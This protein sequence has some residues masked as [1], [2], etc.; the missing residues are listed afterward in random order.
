M[1]EK[2]KLSWITFIV[3]GQ[4]IMLLIASGI[5]GITGFLSRQNDTSD[6]PSVYYEA[7]KLDGASTAKVFVN[8]TL[9]MISPVIFYVLIMQMVSAL[10]IFTQPFIMT[11]GGPM[12]STYTFGLHLYNQAFRY[13]DFGY[14]CAL[15]WVLFAMIMGI[16]MVIF[17]TSR[18]WV[19][20]REDVDL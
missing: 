16:S 17:K 14:S 4:C 13:Y 6:V 1:K 15:A 18:L 2:I 7:A 3:I 5:I 8:I 10:Q 19:F 20:Y 11:Q 9:P 12:F